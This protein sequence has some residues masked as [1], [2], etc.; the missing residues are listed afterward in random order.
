MQN[1]SVDTFEPQTVLYL[2]SAA[3][4]ARGDDRRAR[5]GN[6]PHLSIEKLHGHFWLGD[7]V[8]S[9]TPTAPIC[10]GQLNHLKSL[11]RGEDLA[12]RLGHAL[13]MA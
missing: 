2:H 3:G 9:G 4:I 6:M 10:L 1:G 5:V 7:V 13:P 12:R 11:N 8:D